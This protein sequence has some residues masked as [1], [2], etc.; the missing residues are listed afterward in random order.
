[1]SIERLPEA[2][3]QRCRASGPT[4]GTR[5]SARFHAPA[6]C[7]VRAVVEQLGAAVGT[8]DAQMSNWR[9]DSDLSRLNHAAL[10]EWIA[11]APNFAI[12]LT[13]A[14]SIGRATGNAFN[15]GVGALVGA[16]G[17]GPASDDGMRKG[18]ASRP[19]RPLDEVLEVDAPNCRARRHAAVSFDLCGIAKGFGVDELARVLD[20]Y[21]I[22]SWLV[23]IDGEMRTRGRKPDGSPWAIAIEAPKVD[24]R[25]PMGVIELDDAA[26]ATSGN[27]RHWR[28]IDGKRIS[29]TMDP[30]TG[31]PLIDGLASVTV[32]AQD[33]TDADA[34]ATALLVL[35]HDAS[36]ACATR[37]ALSVL[38]VARDGNALRSSGTGVFAELPQQYACRASESGWARGQ[39]PSG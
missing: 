39:S 17:F 7:D 11:V 18:M 12:V 8:V 4:M 2:R 25:E 38:L 9:D 23:G 28:H 30:R 21:D 20:R 35:G 6:D 16:W 1:M 5:W 29:H 27:Y 36:L 32:V 22:G 34:F 14:L 19:C 33:C 24:R 26:I 37:H 3:L 10:G 15:I 13:R 31:K